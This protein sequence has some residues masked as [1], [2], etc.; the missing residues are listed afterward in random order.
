MAKERELYQ[1][2]YSK[3]K[4]K[5]KLEGDIVKSIVQRNETDSKDWRS[6]GSPSQKE[7]YDSSI[8]SL[9][10]DWMQKKEKRSRK[11]KT[12]QEIEQSKKFA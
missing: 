4:R 6:K 12:K 2:G 10:G 1:T 8:E 9:Y 5:K 3:K 7:R 11:Q